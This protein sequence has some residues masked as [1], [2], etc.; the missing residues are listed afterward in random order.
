MDESFGSLN[1]VG[2]GGPPGD[3]V[4]VSVLSLF[5]RRLKLSS[6]SLR[7]CR[8]NGKSPSQPPLPVTAGVV[9]LSN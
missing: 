4:V 8:D 9:V 6:R 5:S 7:A 1:P 2:V 3:T